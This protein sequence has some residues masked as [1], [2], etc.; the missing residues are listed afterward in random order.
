MT[1]AFLMPEEATIDLFLRNSLQYNLGKM[2]FYIQF[3]IFHLDKIFNDVLDMN[4]RTFLC[5]KLIR[6]ALITY[7]KF[8]VKCANILSR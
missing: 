8:Y 3:S 4:D 6:I 1:F 2:I 7:A 5:M